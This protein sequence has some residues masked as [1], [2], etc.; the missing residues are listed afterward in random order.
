ME[1]VICGYIRVSS[2]DQNEDRRRIA[3][4]EAGVE[5]RHIFMDKQS[6]KDFHR[7][8]Y[9]RLLKKMKPGDTLMT[10]SGAESFYLT[11]SDGQIRNPEPG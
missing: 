7:P 9:L 5:N 10:V 2:R 6:G 4:R 8:G 1:N 11:T 3:M